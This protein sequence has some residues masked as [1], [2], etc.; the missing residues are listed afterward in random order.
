MISRFTHLILLTIVLI[1]QS[2]SQESQ[3]IFTDDK[4]YSWNNYAKEEYKLIACIRQS[5]NNDCDTFFIIL[6]K[7]LNISKYIK[8]GDGTIRKLTGLT[9]EIA[10]YISE[11]DFDY[12]LTIA[13]FLD[14]K[15]YSSRKLFDTMLEY[16]LLNDST[17]LIANYEL[18]KLRYKEDYIGLAHFLI[19]HMHEFYPENSEVSRL[20]KEIEKQFGDST[21]NK[22]LTYKQYLDLNPIY[23]RPNE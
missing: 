19:D 2:C 8:R 12:F 17:N 5:I 22:A 3:Q 6:E 13:V 18:A 10:K 15:D 23:V 7:E 11:D 21:Y 1:H 4:F 9:G 14:A 16:C 20:K